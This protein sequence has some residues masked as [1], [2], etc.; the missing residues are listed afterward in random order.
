MQEKPNARIGV[1][2]SL[3]KN[4]SI[5]VPEILQHVKIQVIVLINMLAPAKRNAKK[6]TNTKLAECY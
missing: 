1:L 3:A 6:K 2:K 4:A 5:G